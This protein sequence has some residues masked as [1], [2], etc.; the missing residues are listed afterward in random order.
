ML[1]RLRLVI[2]S[3]TFSVP[4]FP[5]SAKIP[6]FRIP[7]FTSL[8]A[9]SLGQS[10]TKW[11]ILG[12]V[13]MSAAVVVVGLIF[14]IRDVTGST[15]EWPRA[16]AEYNA[17]HDGHT[18]G[19]KLPAYEDGSESQTLQVNL[20]DG[21][22][23]SELTF[24]NMELGRT[25]LTDCVVVQRAANTTGWLNVGEFNV[26]GTTSAP[27][28]NISNTEAATL[29]V[30][31]IADGHTSGATIDPTIASQEVFSLRGSG[32]FVSD[33]GIVDRIIINLAGNNGA[34]VKEVTFEDVHC[35]V[36]GWNIDYV[37]AGEYSQA[38]T[39]RWGTGSG[40]NSADWVSE[41]T[42]KARTVTDTIQ[43]QPVKV[44]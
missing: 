8:P 5:G 42:V 24:K 6:S 21:A 10:K 11:V 15:Y 43:D 25:G 26:T 33:G 14:A 18:L 30:A 44:Q 27:S 20:A 41:S 40:I 13:G 16:G 36:G 39:T 12:I 1:K 7:R 28:L 38:A 35:S 2:K 22:R 32:A 19:Q 4:R 23:L 31:G 37:K 3:R 9:L 17:L 34:I 29:T